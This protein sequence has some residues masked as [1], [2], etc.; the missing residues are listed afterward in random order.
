MTCLW[1]TFAWNFTR[2]PQWMHSTVLPGSTS[3]ST[4][5]LCMVDVVLV[6]VPMTK[7]IGTNAPP[8]ENSSGGDGGN[9]RSAGEGLVLDAVRLGRVAP[10]LLAALGLVL[11]EVALEPAHLRV[12]LERQ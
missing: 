2:S 12:A 7:N 1:R 9:G 6:L 11:A 8:P 5:R 3:R 4:A 10:E